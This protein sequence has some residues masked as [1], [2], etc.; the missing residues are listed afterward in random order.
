M[1]KN[2]L[3][4]GLTA[5]AVFV[6]GSASAAVMH[7]TFYLAGHGGVSDSYSWSKGG[8]DLTA[9]GH[10]LNHDGSIG[11]QKKIGQ[12]SRGLGVT[13]YH[14]DSHMVDGGYKKETV[15]F[16]FN[17]HVTIEKVWFSYNDHNDD[18]EFTVV[19]G[20]SAGTY[21]SDIDINGGFYGHYSFQGDWTAS[22]FGIGSDYHSDEFKIKK[23]KVSYVPIP[24]AGLMLLTGLAGL[25]LARR[26]RG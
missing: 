24:A 4:A 1:S 26:F 8:L 16:S 17:R 2:L 20:A 25:G 19:D 7:E 22:M 3:K 12:Y 23:I 14:G 13:S 18:F 15:K 21:Y 11:D 6:G 9:T 5:I 10:I